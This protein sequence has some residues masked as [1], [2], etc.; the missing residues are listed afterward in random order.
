MLGT[1]HPLL[2]RHADSPSAAS[3]TH[4]GSSIFQNSQSFTHGSRTRYHAQRPVTSGLLRQGAV[5]HRTYRYVV[6]AQPNNN[7]PAILQR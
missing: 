1:T 6:N 2:I 7:S 4:P 3:T 5:R